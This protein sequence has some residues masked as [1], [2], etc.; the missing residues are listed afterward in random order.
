MTTKEF[1]PY[2]KCVGTG[3]ESL[4]LTRNPSEAFEKL[5]KL[6]AAVILFLTNKEKSI[7]KAYNL[8]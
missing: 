7:E 5:A 8:L 1:L 3:E 6:N 4:T 2:L